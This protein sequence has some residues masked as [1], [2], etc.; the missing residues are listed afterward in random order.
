M[1][2]KGRIVYWAKFGDVDGVGGR[3]WRLEKVER[4]LEEKRERMWELER[5]RHV[6]NEA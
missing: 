5:W 4:M 2:V 6:D 3:V 1:Q